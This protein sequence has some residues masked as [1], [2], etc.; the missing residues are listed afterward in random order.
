MIEKWVAYGADRPSTAGRA[1]DL[2]PASGSRQ[3]TLD[4]LD[5]DDTDE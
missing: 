4:D 2:R 5:D 3:I 1:V